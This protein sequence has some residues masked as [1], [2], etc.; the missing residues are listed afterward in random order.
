LPFVVSS[1]LVQIAGTYKMSFAEEFNLDLQLPQVEATGTKLRARG[2]DAD[3]IEIPSVVVSG[4]SVALPT[5]AVTISKIAVAGL[6]VQAWMS[7]DG[8]INIEQLFAP[9]TASPARHR[10][11]GTSESAPTCADLGIASIEPT[12]ASI[13][14][15]RSAEPARKFAVSA[16]FT[17]RTRA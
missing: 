3:W 4:T 1:G 2:S 17:L 8:S 6:Q 10:A 15:D 5:Q 12:D 13:D 16:E 14:Q 7:P 11:S 9:A